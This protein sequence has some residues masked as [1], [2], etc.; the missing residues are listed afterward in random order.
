MYTA[1]IALDVADATHAVLQSYSQQPET[2]QAMEK[3]E[4][5]VTDAAPHSYGPYS[6]VLIRILYF[7][8][9]CHDCIL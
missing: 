4:Q 9:A 2:F 5:M 7:A 3:R 1:T 8:G 6:I